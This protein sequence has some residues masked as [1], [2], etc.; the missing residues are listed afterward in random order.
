L[1]EKVNRDKIM[2]DKK[3]PKIGNPPKSSGLRLKSIDDGKWIDQYGRILEEYTNAKGERD[4]RPIG[5]GHANH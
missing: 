1:G 3:Q 5:I 4:L 2:Q